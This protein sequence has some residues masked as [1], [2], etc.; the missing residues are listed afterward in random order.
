MVRAAAEEALALTSI[1]LFL[2]TLAVLACGVVGFF[3]PSR[4]GLSGPGVKVSRAQLWA[5]IAVMGLR[6]AGIAYPRSPSRSPAVCAGRQGQARRNGLVLRMAAAKNGSENHKPGFVHLH[7]HSVL[8]AAL[9]R[10]LTIARLRRACEKRTASRRWRLTDT[11][12]MFRAPELLEKLAGYGI[13]PIVGCALGI[14]FGDQGRAGAVVDSWPRV[15]LLAMNEDGYRSLMPFTLRAYLET[16]QHERPHPQ[17]RLAG[18]RNRR[19]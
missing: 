11:D 12:N 16:E 5:T 15:V 13:Q 4:A 18:R 8:L 19:A 17:A 3:D 7:V 6:R 1:S 14:D 10:R 2:A 9:R